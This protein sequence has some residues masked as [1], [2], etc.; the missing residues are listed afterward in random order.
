MAG[1]D[2][3]TILRGPAIVTFNG[4]TFYTKDDVRIDMG[5]D[6]FDIANSIYGKVDERVSERRVN[7]TFTPSGEWENL[8]VLFPYSSTLIGASI[9]GA[10]DLPL[11]IWSQAGTKMTF[12]A[13]AITRMPSI[14]FSTTKTLLGPVTFTCIIGK[15]TDWVT[16][17]NLTKIETAA[18]TDPALFSS[19]AVIT[20]PYTVKWGSTAPWGDTLGFQTQDGV[21]MDFDLATRPISTDSLGIV[22]ITFERLVV[23]ARCIP[24]GVSE[25]DITA[26]L[27]W[28]GT[29]TGATR[30]RSL[31]S[32]G[33][34]FTITGTGVTASITGANLKTAPLAYGPATLRVGEVMFVGTRTFQ[35]GVAQ[36]LFAVG[37]S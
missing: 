4:A 14:S 6:T 15:S 24:L 8:T 18:F 19:A 22:D 12:T 26:A 25:T 37:T 36:P 3:T 1:I 29:L 21:L 9:Y 11:V 20:Q 13:A 31:G 23:S 28:T 2:R 16:A 35:A 34:A 7:V 17:D 10:T 30:G 5:L 27:K 33:Q 32:G